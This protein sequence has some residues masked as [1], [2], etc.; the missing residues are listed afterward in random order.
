[1]FG[2]AINLTDVTIGVVLKMLS[3]A[4]VQKKVI[5]CNNANKSFLLQVMHTKAIA[6][7][8][9]F[10]DFYHNLLNQQ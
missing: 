6:A 4:V 10:C 8:T 2:V 9:Q 3:I 5:S 1:M 7:L